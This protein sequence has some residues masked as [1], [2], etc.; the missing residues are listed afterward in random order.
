[1]DVEPLL[2]SEQLVGC[3]DVRGDWE[4][5]AS[6]TL[7]PQGAWS[8]W[9]K[10][11]LD[12]DPATAWCEGA[13]GPGVGSWIEL[14]Y[15]PSIFGPGDRTLG[16]AGYV[17][18]PGYAHSQAVWDANRRLSA[19]RIA[20]CDRPDGGVVVRLGEEKQPRLPSRAEASAM[21]IQPL[22]DDP[23]GALLEV[24]RDEE[25]PVPEPRPRRGE[26]CVRLTIL[27]VTDGRFPE[28]C[29]SEF[30]PVLYCSPRPPFQD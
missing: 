9:P 20:P 5:R 12:R 15:H 26:A 29:I 4:V 27:E 25:G 8:Y 10:N 2:R 30:R 28:A 18:V 24:D 22:P 19:F 16:F 23:I 11:V 1:M 6:S 3:N 17:L 7:A 13:A 14:V 21:L